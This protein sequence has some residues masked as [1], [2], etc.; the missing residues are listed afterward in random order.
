M[1]RTYQTLKL[2]YSNSLWKEAV[3]QD[4]PPVKTYYAVKAFFE[5]RLHVLFSRRKI[6]GWLGIVFFFATIVVFFSGNP[7]QHIY[8]T[9]VLALAL[10]VRRF[11]YV[12]QYMTWSRSMKMGLTL[13]KDSAWK[14]HRITISD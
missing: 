8:I 1:D 9:A 3:R 10:F 12:Q 14:D 7:P 2:F 4:M 5:D 11:Y 6:T 13:L